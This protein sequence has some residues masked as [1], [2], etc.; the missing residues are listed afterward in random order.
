[1]ASRPVLFALWD[2]MHDLILAR[3]WIRYR[4]IGEVENWLAAHG[5][6]IVDMGSR[7]LGRYAHESMLSRRSPNS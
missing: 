1:M 6:R 3:Q 4:A 5:A 2:R 7:R